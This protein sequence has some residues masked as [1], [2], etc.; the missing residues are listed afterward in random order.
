VT[1]SAASLEPLFHPSSVAVI[2][3]SADPAKL[4]GRSLRNL[5][6]QPFPG[7]VYA[8]NSR[9]EQ[10]QGVPAYPSITAV[11]QPVDL[12]VVV[13]P[14]ESVVTAIEQCAER[15]V[16]SAIV[17]SSGFAEVDEKGRAAQARLTAIARA[18]G[19]RILGP[20]CMGVFDPAR[21]LY[22][23]FS[24]SFDQ[25]VPKVGPIGIASQSGAFG[26][27]C[28]V[29]ARE[30]GLGLSLWATTGNE[31]DVDIAECLE[32]M[33]HDPGTKVVLGYLEGCR[34]KGRLIRALEAMAAKRKPLVMLKVGRSDVGAQA[35][36]SHTASL[37]GSDRVYDGLFR[38]YGVHRAESLEDLMDIGYACTAGRF[39]TAGRVGLVSISGGVGVLMADAARAAG[40]EVPAMP[41]AAQDKLKALLPYAA[42][43]NPGDATGQVLAD[44]GLL[45]ANLEVMYREGGCD[46]VV[47]FL[48]TVGINP[49]LMPKLTDSLIGLRKRFPDP[50]AVVCMLSKPD[51]AQPLE[52]AGY[53]VIE[54]ATRGIQSVA[55]LVEYG[56]YFARPRDAGALPPLPRPAALPKGPIGEFE[57]KRILKDAGIPIAPERLA[58]SAQEARQAAE[59]IGYPVVLK[60]A[61]PDI[62]H[63]SEM[64]GVLLGVADSAEA[65][66]GFDLLLER[67]RD[68]APDARVDGVLVAPQVQGGVEALLGV[69]RDPVFGPVVVFGLG[70]IYVE[71]LNDIALRI[72]PFGVDEARRMV[73]EIKAFPLLDGARGRPKADVEA[74][75]QTLS[76][77]SLFAA[78][79]ADHL[80]SL[81]INPFIVL[82]EGQGGLAVD[83]LIVSRS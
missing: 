41:Q 72:A 5:L 69:H 42:V 44:L 78:A 60:I 10:V 68:A 4:G 11:P 47:V 67:A 15:G 33:A 13:V 77:L 82:P 53:L 21:H 71:V 49:V 7:P 52:D 26:A 14:G 61:S 75:A 40:L 39:P 2:G 24:A 62:A 8:I 45:G 76:R 29:V 51:L 55:A 18:S 28:F 9:A 74:L 70:G 46:A 12:A 83:A 48:G 36:A 20:N 64:G 57:A 1:N 25:G 19:M 35:A 73:R 65:A 80:Q 79:Q 27:Y 6:Q 66:L 59:H 32:F 43:R 30:R 34:D 31:C 23:T 22:A 54:D 17:F 63:K 16:K 3:A 58:R 81:D 56:R 38:Q 37:A 50:V